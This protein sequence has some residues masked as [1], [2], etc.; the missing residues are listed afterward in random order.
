[1]TALTATVPPIK[2]AVHNATAPRAYALPKT[3][4]KPVAAEA[5][6]CIPVTG[7]FQTMGPGFQG[8]LTSGPTTLSSLDGAPAAPGARMQQYAG[9]PPFGRGG[10]GFIPGRPG[11]GGGGGGGGDGGGG[12]GFIPPAIT[13]DV[14]P[15][16]EPSTWA[17]L[18][19]GFAIA[20]GAV[21][22]S[23]G[24]RRRAIGTA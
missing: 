1:M 19:S 24:R 14:S 16:P 11:G 9:A 13:P 7:P 5:P 17:Q 6:P 2:K 21:R 22:Y 12:G 15:I 23:Q 20:G 8:P 18:I 4:V 10:G 3:H